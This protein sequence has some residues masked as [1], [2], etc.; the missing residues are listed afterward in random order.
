MDKKKKLT[1]EEYKSGYE[2]S[3]EM[4]KSV[5]NTVTSVL[6]AIV[7]MGAGCLPLLIS[8]F[9]V[10]KTSPFLYIVIPLAIAFFM[11]TFKTGKSSL[12]LVLLLLFSIIGVFVVN[13]VLFKNSNDFTSVWNAFFSESFY[14]YIFILTG[15]L[16][17]YDCVISDKLNPPKE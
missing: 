11:I 5:S 8:I 2:N 9:T 17:G 7:G 15:S 3:K 16:V 6:A 1:V 14:S 4:E 12:S 13:F 10:G